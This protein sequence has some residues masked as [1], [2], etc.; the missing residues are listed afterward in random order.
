MNRTAII[1]IALLAASVTVLAQ[2]PATP[3]KE[4]PPPGGEPKDLVLAEPARMMLDNGLAATLVEYGTAP[5]VTVYARVR[6]G[7]LNEGNDVWLAAITGDMLKEGTENYSSTALAEAAASMGG[8]ISIMTDDEYTSVSMDVLSE[9]ADEA[10]AL[11]AELL[12]RPT[13]PESE[14]ERIRRDY[15]RSLAVQQSQPQP[16]AQ[17]AFVKLLYGSHPFGRTFPTEAQLAGYGIADVERFYEEN[18]GARRTQVYVAGRFRRAFVEQALRDQFGP[19]EPGPEPLVDVPPE[20]DVPGVEL[21]E[22]PGAPQS[23]LRLGLRTVDPAAGIN[24]SRLAVANTLFGGYFSSRVTA[25]IRE[26]KGYTY[27]PSSTL[28][29]RKGDAYWVQQADVTTEHTGDSLR[30]IFAELER[31][32]SDPPG[33]AEV[34]RVHNYL[35]GT[36]TLSNSSRFG[37]LSQ[38]AFIDTHGLPYEYL[39]SYV[40]RVT[41]VTAEQISAAAEQ[42]LVPDRMSLVVVGDLEAVR[43]QLEALPQIEGRL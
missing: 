7:G 32:R 15:L 13:L 11:V 36:F 22:R 19:W 17:A 27:S 12:R 14:L 18:F 23:T 39:T 33:P 2:E 20:R 42:F 24:W 21:I 3:E 5:K 41:G 16:L 29:A 10:V 35:V 25:N 30:E 1:L 34:D 31:L 9:F 37:I 4:T 43:P 40:E 8:D 28:S 38:L 26:D 6:A